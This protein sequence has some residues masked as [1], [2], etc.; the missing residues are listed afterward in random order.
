MA[1]VWLGDSPFSQLT[2]GTE[3][4]CCAVQARGRSAGTDTLIAVDQ[5]RTRALSEP[6]VRCNARGPSPLVQDDMT[7]WSEMDSDAQLIGWATAGDG[8]AF[9]QLIGRYQRPVYAYLARRVDPP[10]AEDLLAEVWMAAFRGRASFDPRFESARPWLFTI[11][12]NVLRAHWGQCHHRVGMTADVPCDPWPEVDDR[13][14]A[15]DIA[16][17]LRAAV[18]ALPAEQREVLLLVAWEDLTPSEV[19]IVL[20]LPPGTV[21]SHLHRARRALAEQATVLTAVKQFNHVKET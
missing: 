7:A 18:R 9:A 21:R 20:D 5:V 4:V 6:R 10:V 17:T 12:R 8:G 3:T 1:R 15:A 13:L 19:A 11:A 2:E 16:E 14:A